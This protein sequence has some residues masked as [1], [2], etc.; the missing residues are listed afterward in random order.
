[1]AVGGW[2]WTDA[3]PY[4]GYSIQLPNS[5]SLIRILLILEDGVKEFGT[6]AYPAPIV[7]HKEARERC[8]Q[9]FK[10][11]LALA[12]QSG[13]LIKHIIWTLQIT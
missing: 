4:F 1:M 12:D 9:T 13:I 11:G 8:L 7:D 10:V 3:A 6:D 2:L 5:K